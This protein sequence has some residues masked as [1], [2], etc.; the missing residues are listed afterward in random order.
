MK[1]HICI[2]KARH[3][4]RDINKI[5]GI[6]ENGQKR[7]Y[8]AAKDME[9]AIHKFVCESEQITHRESRRLYKDMEEKLVYLEILPVWNSFIN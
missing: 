7:Y 6:I 1:F 8:K 5:E 2:N 3:N 9:Q 4:I